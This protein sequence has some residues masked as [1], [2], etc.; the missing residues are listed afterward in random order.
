MF[1]LEAEILTSHVLGFNRSELCLKLRLVLNKEA[2][3]KAINVI[4]RRGLQ[5]PLQYI[6]GRVSFRE[7]VLKIDCKT[8]IPRPETERLVEMVTETLSLSVEKI[9]ELGVGSG[10][11]SI[12]VAKIYKLPK[13]LA[14]DNESKA[15]NSTELNISS[16][17][18]KMSV[19]SKINQ[20]SDN[21]F[22]NFDLIISNPPY[23]NL[24][25]WISSGVEIKNFE[26]FYALVSG[27]R[28][29]ARDLVTIIINSFSILKKSGL[30]IL[31]TGT[32]CH[33]VLISVAFDCGYSGRTSHKDLLNYNRFL[34]LQK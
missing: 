3:R 12:S 9:L 30:L 24:Q 13:I 4:N 33:H 11:I 32:N 34:V 1:R 15:I 31:E 21:L 10:S 23:L 25:E 19:F 8:L 5:E 27:D 14:V 20:W 16:N 26:P 18:A 29:G 2:V 17:N 7:S 28:M 22:D 6:I